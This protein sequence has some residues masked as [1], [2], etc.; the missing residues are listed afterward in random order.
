MKSK[1]LFEVIIKNFK[2][3]GFV[4]SEPDVLLDSEY[5]IERSGEKFRNSMLTFDREDGKTM[6]LR[7]DLTVASCI[8]FLQKKTSSKIYY[9]GQAYRRSGNK[10]SNFINDQLGIEILGSKNE[11]QDDFKVISTILSSAKKIKS[12]KIQ[13]KVGDISLFKSLIN[14]LEMPE[15]WKLRLIR[16]FW[17]PK[18]F[19]ELLRRL[20][21]NTDIDAV[22]FDTDKKR[23]YEMKKMDQEKVIAG[24][25]ISEILK[26]FNKKIKDPRSFSEGK[27][28]VKIIKSFLK[29]NCKLSNLD[30]ILLDFA[31]KNNLKKNIFK[32]FKSIQN[33]KRVKQEVNFI[34]NFGRDVE[35][36][37]GIVFE[38]FSENKEI[39][40]GGRYDNLLKSLGAKKNIPAVGAAINLKNI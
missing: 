14:A 28:I 35:Y 26:R 37:T 8:N 25:S 31:K 40:R 3:N 27:Q 20:E 32:N 18:Y 39:A 33:L 11:I 7:P 36:Y 13:I 17:R 29:I 16:H 34:A 2:S 9:S 21:K 15:R 12:K 24:R 19:E 4:L 23:F 5:I 38:V 1:K 22:T 6:C 10:G 30:K